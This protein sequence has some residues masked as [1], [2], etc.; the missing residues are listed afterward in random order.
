MGRSVIAGSLTLSLLI[1][2]VIIV[3]SRE[4]LKAV[5]RSIRE[6]AYA[7][8]AT[9]WQAI[10]AHVMPAAL[11]GVLT[12]V[13]LALSRAL[14]ETAPLIVVGAVAYVAFVPEGPMSAFTVLPIQIYDWTSRPQEAFHGIAAAGIVVLLVVLLSLN[15]L[16]IVIRNHYQRKYRW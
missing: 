7:L 2:P 15:A 4:A 11:P 12:G 16:A 6:A 5:P 1:L 9:R 10:R 8:G 13:I 3:A 14:G